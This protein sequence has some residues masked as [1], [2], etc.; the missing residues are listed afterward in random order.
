[1]SSLLLGSPS[2]LLIW[3]SLFLLA[4]TNNRFFQLLLSVLSWHSNI[5]LTQWSRWISRWAVWFAG[6][7]TADEPA[8][9]QAWSSSK[10][11]LALGGGQM[12]VPPLAYLTELW[13]DPSHL[14]NNPKSCSFSTEHSHKRVC[15]INIGAVPSWVRLVIFNTTALTMTLQSSLKTKALDLWVDL[16]K[17]LHFIEL[18]FQIQ[19]SGGFSFLRDL[20]SYPL[21]QNILWLPEAS[22]FVAG[23]AGALTWMMLPSQS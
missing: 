5:S 9:R 13:C 6:A 20:R 1:M 11:L 17:N 4:V 10:D 22:I 7:C 16:T 14:T 2:Y 15:N 3:F 21:Q 18:T 23:I 8:P 19:I 12:L